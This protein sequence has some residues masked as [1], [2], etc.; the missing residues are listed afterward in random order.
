MALKFE[1]WLLDQQKRK[2][3][4]GDLA[5][6][7]TLLQTQQFSSRRKVDEHKRWADVFISSTNPS[8][9]AIFNEAWQEFILARQAIEDRAR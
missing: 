1:A 7:A 9:I 2:D 8:H 3:L 5:R 6:A 4:I